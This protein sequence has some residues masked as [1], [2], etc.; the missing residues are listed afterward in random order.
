MAAICVRGLPDI[1][2]R[3][4]RVQAAHAGLS[5][6][7]LA[8]R[9]LIDGLLAERSPAGGVVDSGAVDSGAAGGYP[10]GPEPDPVE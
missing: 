7:E 10:G 1:A 4:L 8:R 6:E 9:I 3:L 2:K 5:M